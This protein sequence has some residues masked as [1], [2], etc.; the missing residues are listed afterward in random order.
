TADAQ[1]PANWTWVQSTYN[2]ASYLPVNAGV[3][4]RYSGTDGAQVNVDLVVL[5]GTLVPVELQR[6]T[7]E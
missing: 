6:F 5:D 7:V 3:G 2:V 1:W 4:L